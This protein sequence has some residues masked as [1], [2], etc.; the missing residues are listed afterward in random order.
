M[1]KIKNV[2]K[3]LS[4]STTLANTMCATAPTNYL[5]EYIVTPLE[6]SCS[7]ECRIKIKLDESVKSFALNINRAENVY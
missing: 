7:V 2:C 1:T 6:T 5:A 4:A 3:G